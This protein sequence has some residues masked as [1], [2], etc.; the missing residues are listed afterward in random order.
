MAFLTGWSYRKPVTLS[1]ASGAVTLY[2]MK[3]LVGESSGATGEDVDC[4]GLCKTDFSDLRFTAA[5]GTTLLDYWIESVSGTTPNQLATIW[6]EFDSIGT[7]ATTFYMYY[8]NAGASAVSNGD[9]AFLFFDDF[10]DGSIDTNKWTNSGTFSE[11]GGTAN[12]QATNGNTNYLLVGK[13]NIPHPCV[14]RVKEKA[15]SDWSAAADRAWALVLLWDTAWATQGYLAGHYRNVDTGDDFSKIFVFPAGTGNQ[16][17][18]AM[19]ADTYYLLDLYINGTNQ[20]YHVNGVQKGTI[21]TT[22]PAASKPLT[23]VHSSSSSSDFTNYYDYVF[24]RQWTAS[25]VEPAWGAWGGQ[26]VDLNHYALTME[27]G[28]FAMIGSPAALFCDKFI[29]LGT[30]SYSMVG[31]DASFPKALV[32]LTLGA[33]SFA[34]TGASVRLHKIGSMKM[35]PGTYLIDGKSVNPAYSWYRGEAASNYQFPKQRRNF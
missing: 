10:N 20:Y 34:M 31:K 6:I 14:L 24:A 29:S 19:S 33:G 12:K 27:A 28:S 30:S 26:E 4:G 5:D 16:T 15:G 18:E 3:L 9:N 8:G 22:P 7:G 35:D 11:S 21:A 13:T 25:G 2:Q 1:R 32:P 17:N 23:L